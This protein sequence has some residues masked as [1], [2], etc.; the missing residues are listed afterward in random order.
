M[1]YCQ[2]CGTQLDDDSRFCTQCGKNLS[3]PSQ[4]APNPNYQFNRPDVNRELIGKLS[5]RLKTNGIIWIVIASIQ[6]LIG[7]CGVWF[8]L[9]VGVLNLI[10]AI[11]DIKSSNRIL[12]DQSNIVGTYESLVSPI[13]TLVYNA[14]IGGII[15]IAGSIY[16]LTCVRGFVMENKNRF[17]A[18]ENNAPSESGSDAQFNNRSAPGSNASTPFKKDINI[19]VFLT[20]QEAFYGVQKDVAVPGLNYPIK[21]NFP[22]NA[23]DGARLIIRDLNIITE[24][25]RSIS[26][27]LN[28]LVRIQCQKGMGY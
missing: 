9:I 10:S 12:V 22:G 25:G 26:T 1:K 5:S 13:I 11:T 20:E 7:V 24:D 23:K 16:Y 21:V 4:N 3:Q 6:I 27:D 15:G 28:I 17:L 2:Y 14:V 19:V 8:T 18:M